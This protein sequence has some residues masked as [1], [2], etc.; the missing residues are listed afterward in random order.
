[1]ND[2]PILPQDANELHR[3]AS[4]ER[5]AGR[6][7]EAQ[8]LLR[9]IVKIYEESL[10]PDNLA[11][12]LLELAIIERALG[13]PIQALRWLY[14]AL[15]IRKQLDDSG[16]QATLRNEIAFTELL[17]NA[18]ETEFRRDETR[19]QAGQS[20]TISEEEGDE[21]RGLQAGMLSAFVVGE[22]KF[23]EFEQVM[24]FV[25]DLMR[26]CYLSYEYISIKYF[27][28]IGC[29]LAGGGKFPGPRRSRAPS[30]V[31]EV[32]NMIGMRLVSIPPGEFLMGSADWE[33][34]AVEDE[35]PRHRVRITRPFS[36]GMH[37]VTQRQYRRVI[38]KN[39]SY[40]RDSSRDRTENPVESVSWFDAVR[41]CNRLSELEGLRPY[42]RI[43]GWW[44][45][46]VTVPQTDGEGYRLPTEAEWEYA[47]RAGTDLRYG[48]N[49]SDWGLDENVWYANNCGRD[50]LDATAV[51]KRLGSGS[52]Y[53]QCLTE[54]HGCS[55]QPVGRKLANGFGLHDMQG[56]VW[57]WCWD[58]HGAYS[59]APEQDPTG[60]GHGSRRV[61][62]GGSWYEPPSLMFRCSSRLVARDPASAEHNSGFRV[63][64][65]GR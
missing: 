34:E 21:I 36:L 9:Q 54:E 4:I 1:M 64:R 45:T 6:L 7:V 18:G 50:E 20:A 55:T 29:R 57:E 2:D 51:Y 48:F 27:G 5:D 56:N 46:D 44:W 16:G 59:S 25:R 65:N 13:E 53:F 15:G 43:S 42:Y 33:S 23:G 26:D 35:G 17:R 49:E 37:P 62:R 24:A 14:Q 28:L 3:K 58:W 38:G 22:E 39:P 12:S 30:S 11:S 10:E 52:P 61:R 32:V 47:C 41:F 31:R 8:S 63:A 19:K 40:F 60:P